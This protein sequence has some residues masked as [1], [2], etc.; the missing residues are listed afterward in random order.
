MGEE[1]RGERVGSECFE[2]SI[3]ASDRA[4]LRS[5]VASEMGEASDGKMCVTG[6]FG[7]DSVF[8]ARV[9]ED[10]NSV[11]RGGRGWEKID[12]RAP[13]SHPSAYRFSVLWRFLQR[14]CLNGL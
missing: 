8:R 10:R 13:L 4:F 11:R 7:R 12:G 3:A 5:R 9:G 14:F 2:R 6:N 1:E